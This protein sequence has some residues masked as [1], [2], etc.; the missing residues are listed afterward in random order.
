MSERT[1]LGLIHPD[2]TG[3]KWWRVFAGAFPSAVADDIVQDV[4][5]VALP[6]LREQ[7]DRL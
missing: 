5:A 4:G 3:D 2:N 6:W 1:R 7:A